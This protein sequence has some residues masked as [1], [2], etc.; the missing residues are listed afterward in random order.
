MES[1][2]RQPDRCLGGSVGD[3]R[4]LAADLILVSQPEQVP[5]RHPQ[6][7]PTDNATQTIELLL[8]GRSVRQ[9]ACHLGLE[10]IDVG[11]QPEAT[12][13]SQLRKEVWEPV[14][15]PANQQ[16]VTEQPAEPLRCDRVV[17]QHG[18]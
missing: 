4:Q 10:L 8:P 13:V 3:G 14:D 15:V 17:A 7:V 18:R 9:G 6:D 2:P 5:G 16:A 11:R 1:L 12:V